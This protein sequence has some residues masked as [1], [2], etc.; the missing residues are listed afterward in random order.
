MKF[1]T[2]GDYNF[3]L[4]ICKK[5]VKPFTPARKAGSP[6][7]PGLGLDRPPAHRAQTKSRPSFPERLDSPDDDGG[8]YSRAKTRSTDTACQRPPRGDGMPR[9]FNAFAKP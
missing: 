6:H 1:A 9:S 5:S 2:V 4:S 7:A 8:D 3:P